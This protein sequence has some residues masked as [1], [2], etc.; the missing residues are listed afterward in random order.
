MLRYKL[1]DTVAPA[2]W[3]IQ[4]CPFPSTLMDATLQSLGGILLRAIPTLILLLILHVYL[5]MMF[6]KPLQEVLRKRREA[7]EGARE[8][9]EASTKHASEKAAEYEAQLKEARAGIYKEQEEMRRQWLDDQT[10]R[11]EK[12]REK[13]H[14]MV[15][16]AK[17]QLDIDIATAKQDLSTRAEALADQIAQTLLERRAN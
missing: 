13:T 15:R 10:Q 1:W 11:I 17:S 16:H 4:T 9:A 2:V 12:A 6:F 3:A 14:A 8:A 7:T 5:K